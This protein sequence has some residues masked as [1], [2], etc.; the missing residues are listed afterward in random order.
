MKNIK[1]LFDGVLGNTV[2]VGAATDWSINLNLLNQD[3]E[4]LDFDS[5]EVK[6]FS[7]ANRE[8]TPEVTVSLTNIA[9]G[10]ATIEVADSNASFSAGDKLYGFV[11]VNN[12]VSGEDSV[13]LN[14]CV[15]FVK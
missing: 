6:F 10:F 5:G 9:Q 12:S 7:A 14:Y 2:T 15:L 3:G 4:K 8:G 1:V 13:G 11:E